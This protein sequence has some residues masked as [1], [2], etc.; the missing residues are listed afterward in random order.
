V[1]LAANIATTGDYSSRQR[2]KLI[3][4]AYIDLLSQIHGSHLEKE[5]NLNA[6]ADAFRLADAVRGQVVQSAM[7]A[8]SA[9]MAVA[10]PVLADL[11]RK[12]QNTDHQIKALQSIISDTLAVPE[13]Q[14]NPSA[15][16]N[17]TATLNTLSKARKALLEEIKI[18]FPKYSD[19]TN[20]QPATI[21][22]VK[23]NLQT[24][25]A[26]ISIY[27]TDEHSYVWAI[28]SKGEIKFF[29]SNMDKK[30]ITGIANQLRKALAPE[31][32]VLGDIPPFDVKQAYTLYK[33]LIKPVGAAWKEAKHL[34]IVSH[35]P[36]GQLPFSILP[37]STPK[38]R[39]DDV[40][41]SNY[42]DV[43]WLIREV[44]S[45]AWKSR[46]QGFCRFRRSFF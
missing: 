9:R 6:P 17:L 7:G 38:L 43:H 36:L 42:R 21:S 32:Q 29:K 30:K 15:I 44:S 46:T 1:L 18:Q 28:P 24:N 35:G 22:L 31:A 25:E 10:N 8:S 41:F 11:V 34:I 2:F 16:E 4:E 27:T 5:L 33:H 19:F 26:L 39:E 40:L 13:N 12:E 14:R 37:T 45:S 3:I 23:N 20:P